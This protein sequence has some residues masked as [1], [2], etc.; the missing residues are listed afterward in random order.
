MRWRFYEAWTF[1]SPLVQA[2]WGSAPKPGWNR[3]ATRGPFYSHAP[4]DDTNLFAAQEPGTLVQTYVWTG[5]QWA[6]ERQARKY[7]GGMQILWSA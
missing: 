4:L 5:A 6:L 7:V 3:V 1:Y 2:T